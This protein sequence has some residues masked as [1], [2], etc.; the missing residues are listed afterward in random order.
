[1]RQYTITMNEQQARALKAALEE[2]FRL[3]IGQWH[4]VTEDWAFAEFNFQAPASEGRDRAFDSAITRKEAAEMM[5]EAAYRV[6][7]PA[8]VRSCA[9]NESR[10][11]E[12]MWQVIRHRLWLDNDGP[13]QMPWSVDGRTLLPVSDEPPIEMREA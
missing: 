8:G 9:T 6:A 1:M 12:D 13:N 4:H 10:I 2:F 7:K 3:R 11:C 5:L